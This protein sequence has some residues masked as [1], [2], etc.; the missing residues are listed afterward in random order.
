M[1]LSKSSLGSYITCPEKYFLAYELRIRPVK[2]PPDLLVGGA[3]HH[4]IAAHFLKALFGE[5]CDLEQALNEFWSRH[6]FENTGFDT[7]DDLEMGKRQS[8]ALAQLFLREARI[9]PLHAEYRFELP[10]LNVQTGEVLDDVE[11]VGIIDLIDRPNGRHRAVEIKTK[12]RKPDDFAAKTSIELTCYAYWLRFLE[13]HGSIPVSYAHIVKTKNPYILWQDQERKEPDFIELFHTIRI[14][15]ANIADR[16]FYR[17]PGVHCGWCDY[18]PVCLRD[19][20]AS[21]KLFGAPALELL[22]EHNRL[23]IGSN[24][25]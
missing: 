15:A 13:E 25:S 19:A 23:G 14:V 1:K 6:E 12:A 17:N 18:R 3:T 11:L 4:V 20:E 9:E 10:I 5:P 22:A 16:R 2:T 24:L 21:R 7:E 8:L